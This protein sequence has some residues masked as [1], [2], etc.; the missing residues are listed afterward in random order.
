V[1]TLNRFVCLLLLCCSMAG[2]RADL[3]SGLVAWYPFDGNAKDASG[4]KNNGKVFGGVEATADRYG[5]AGGA[6]QFNGVDGYVSV[7]DAP[8]LNPKNQ[9]TVAYWIRVD[10]FGAEWTPVVYKGDTDEVAGCLAGRQYTFWLNSGQWAHIASGGDGD[11]SHYLAGKPFAMSGKWNH[12]VQVI[13]RKSAHQMSLYVNGKLQ[14]QVD[15]SYDTFNRSAEPL[16]I[17]IDFEPFASAPFHGALDDLRI[18]DRALGK[19]E[20]TE[21]YRSSLQ[22]AGTTDGFGS[23]SVTC[24]NVT[25]A[26]T[27]TFAS[28]DKATSTW[29]CEAEGLV[30]NAGD[31]VRITLDGTAH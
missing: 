18:F 19:N 13:D 7:P 28:Q 21:L 23:L 5:N 17:G 24:R 26:Q 8:S 29:N 1:S 22:V 27:V 2:A 3:S 10:D 6:M 4:N 25:T 9:V 12:V 15:D 14:V 11:C 20:V 16:L 31:E 30:V